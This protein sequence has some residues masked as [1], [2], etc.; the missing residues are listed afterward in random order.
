MRFAHPELLWLLLLVPLFLVLKGRRG[1]A[2][3]LVFSSTG[4]LE[5]LMKGRKTERAGFAG[6]LN[7]SL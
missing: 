2:V 1:P 4:F 3:S 5:T 6:F 7:F